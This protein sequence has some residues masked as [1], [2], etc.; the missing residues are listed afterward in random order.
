MRRMKI[1]ACLYILGTDRRTQGEFEGIL[2]RL[3]AAGYEGVE[4][5][6]DNLGDYQPAPGGPVLPLAAYHT[7]TVALLDLPPV[8]EY[9]R[10]MDC[11]AVCCSG[12]V[13][14]NQ[15]GREEWEETIR[16]LNT[17]GA[18]LRDQGVALHYHNHGFEFEA[19]AG[20]GTPMDLLLTGRD[21]DV[22]DLC[23]DMG[24][25]WLAGSDP[26]AFLDEHAEKVGFV[27][28]RDFDGE[29]SVELGG[30][31]VPLEPT[32]GRLAGLPN[33]QWA[34]VEQD[35]G[36]PDPVASMEESMEHLRK[37]MR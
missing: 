8:T 27:H 15:R 33:L 11:Q 17:A 14:W 9:L 24:W 7:G 18:R 28:L 31:Q 4:A 35:P 20:G 23:L 16:V 25:Q 12:P 36:V 1:G 19:V 22:V 13:E 37:L 29:R 30:G 34:I 5:L 21:F 6:P 32:V 3:A 2:R 26:A 10:L